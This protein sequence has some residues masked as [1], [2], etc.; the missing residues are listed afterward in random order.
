[1]G[2]MK[3][4]SAVFI[5]S[6]FVSIVGERRKKYCMFYHFFVSQKRLQEVLPLKLVTTD[7]ADDTNCFFRQD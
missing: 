1:M 7:F 3:N 4:F 2:L 6:C 5:C